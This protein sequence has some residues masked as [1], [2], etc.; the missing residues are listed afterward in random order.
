MMKKSAEITKISGAMKRRFF[1]TRINARIRYL[2]RQIVNYHAKK[3]AASFAKGIDST[4]NHNKTSKI[5]RKIKKISTY[6]FSLIVQNINF[7]DNLKKLKKNEEIVDYQ[8]SVE[9]TSHSLH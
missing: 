9:L 7:L 1:K 5:Q 8:I 6:F 4:I 3:R 2:N